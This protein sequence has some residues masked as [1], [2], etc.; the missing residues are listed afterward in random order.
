MERVHP[1]A[2]EVSDEASDGAGARDPDGPSSLLERLRR[3]LALI[4]IPEP[5]RLKRISYAVF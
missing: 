3:D 5:T 1:G 4:H 2:R